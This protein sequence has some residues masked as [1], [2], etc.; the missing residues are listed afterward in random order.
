VNLSAS[1]QNLAVDRPI[2]LERIFRRR[3]NYSFE[4][5][6]QLR[7]RNNLE[8]VLFSRLQNL[9]RKHIR[10]QAEDLRNNQLNLQNSEIRFLESLKLLMAIHYKRIFM[11]IYERNMNIYQNLQKKQD[12]FD[13]SNVDFEKVVA[14]YISTNT[15]RLVGISATLTKNIKKIIEEGYREN[16]SS[17]VIARN[18]EREI[19]TISRTRALIIARTETHSG[20]SFANHKYHV[21]VG[22]SLGIDFYKRWVAV[23]D[24]RTRPEHREANGQTVRMNEKFELSHPKRGTVFMDRAGDPSGGAY[25]SINCRCVITYAENPDDL[26]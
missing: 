13:F 22:D 16:L 6:A 12:A 25:H 5:R 8:L 17:A 2:N 15:I 18:L 11:A 23:S 24:G 4:V 20:A 10:Q 14:G 26:D 9:I 7:L 19:P 1:K 21:D 3:I